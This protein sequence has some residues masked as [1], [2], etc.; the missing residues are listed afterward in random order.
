MDFGP[1]FDFRVAR[2]AELGPP[3]SE[4]G[5]IQVRAL[6]DTGASICAIHQKLAEELELQAF[7]RQILSSSFGEEMCPI[8]L[9]DILDRHDN[10]ASLPTAGYS[11]SSKNFEFL[12]GRNY[13]RKA[14]LSYD[15]TCGTYQL[16]HEH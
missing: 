12:I 3:S 2:P 8:Y 1:L 10:R 13:L 14:R 4:T 9:V 16:D 7:D 11:W 5:G 15:G 6:L